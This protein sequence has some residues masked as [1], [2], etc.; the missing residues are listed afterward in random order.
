MSYT[1]EYPRPSMTVDIVL[2]SPDKSHILCIERL[3]E[4]H[5]S[6]WAL[7]GGFLEL[8]ETLKQ[9]AVRELKEETN[10]E[11][12]VED[13]KFVNIFDQV[14][15]DK[16]GRVISC[17]FTAQLKDY[18]MPVAGDD[19]AKAEWILV[20]RLINKEIPLAFDHYEMLMQAITKVVKK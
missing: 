15:R 20:G 14:D 17:C 5:K 19:A 13:L 7:P 18:K 9:S 16:R 11:L 10:I 2:F 12:K 8:S 1:Y 4:P 6:S 3:K